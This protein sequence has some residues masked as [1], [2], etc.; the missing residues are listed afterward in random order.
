MYCPSCNER[1]VSYLYHWC[2]SG[3][4]ILWDSAIKVAS[5]HVHVYYHSQA[6][7]H[8]HSFCQCLYSSHTHL[9]VISGTAEDSFTWKAASV[10]YPAAYGR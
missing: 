2:F 9:T 3:L 10:T 7:P 1:H 8:K 4:A 6:R 5:L